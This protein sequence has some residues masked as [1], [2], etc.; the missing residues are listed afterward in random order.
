LNEQTPLP[1]LAVGFL[2][3]DEMNESH[4]AATKKEK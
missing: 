3:F 4:A 2:F 1:N